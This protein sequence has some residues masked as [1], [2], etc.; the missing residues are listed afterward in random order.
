MSG[1]HVGS[2]LAG[3]HGCIRK[4]EEW[5]TGNGEGEKRREIKTKSVYIWK[6]NSG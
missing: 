1:T 2:R 6:Y 5:G 3:G 4:R